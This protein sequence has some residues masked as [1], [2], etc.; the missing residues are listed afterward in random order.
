[1]TEFYLNGTRAEIVCF[2]VL[3]STN[4]YLKEECRRGA[5][6]YY[7]VIADRQT[8]GRGRMGRS[9]YSDKGGLY[10]SFLLRNL[11]ELDLTRITAA[12][13]V[14]VAEAIEEIYGV[15]CG[16]K[17]VNDLLYDG[18]KV[19][20]ILAEGVVS[21]N[22]EIEGIVVGIG[23]NIAYPIGGFCDDIKEIAGVISDH[24]SESERN[25]LSKAILKRFER[26]VV[27]T[28]LIYKYRALSTVVGK[29]IRVITQN[30]SYDAKAVG[31]DPSFGLIVTTGDGNNIILRSGEISIR[32]K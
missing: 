6:N 24:Y 20:G 21:D 11:C 18:K 16:I 1:M 13:G 29:E 7:T 23:V 27:S 4:A 17:W 3:P 9:F 31:I 10:M 28:D 19:C 30:G 26:N 22:G 8:N 2:D 14:S 15:L 12:A 5:P 32:T 25:D